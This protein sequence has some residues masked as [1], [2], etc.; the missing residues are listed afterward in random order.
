MI[1]DKIES[2]LMS[3]GKTLNEELLNLSSIKF[4]ESIKRQL[5]QDKTEKLNHLYTTL[6]TKSCARQS[7]YKYHG[8]EGEEL[9]ARTLVNFLMG[10]LAEIAF[11]ILAELAGAK[12]EGN[13]TELKINE[14]DLSFTCRPD[15]VY[16]DP[17]TGKSYNVEIKKMSEYAFD[18]WKEGTLDD[19]W[20]YR[21]QAM[22]E[23][24]AWK[25]AGKDVVG[26]AFLGMR[27]ITGHFHEEIIPFEPGLVDKA[28]N[29]AKQV[30]SSTKEELP[31][32]GVAP[33]A[34]TFR[35]K[36]T[37]KERLNVVCQYCP[38]KQHC[39][40]DFKMELKGGYPRW[41]R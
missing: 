14:G 20:G 9:S 26:T 19:T 4:Q 8:F 25:E 15:G 7:A 31:I 3:K 11:L 27:G 2:Y 40:P 32:R 33:E 6:I 35:N 28:L 39:Y 24:R 22:M 23:C 18:E 12:I 34:E 29:R 37:G 36:P 13:N 41:L 30:V 16:L 17:K 5:M 38:Y 21:T 1:T 10:D